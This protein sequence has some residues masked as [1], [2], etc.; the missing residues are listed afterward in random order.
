MMDQSSHTN[1]AGMEHVV[2][3]VITEESKEFAV[4]VTRLD[5]IIINYNQAS[6]TI[7]RRG[8]SK[9]NIYQGSLKHFTEMRW[10]EFGENSN[11]RIGVNSPRIIR[12]II[13]QVTI[14]E[15]FDM[16]ELIRGA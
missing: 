12:S 4:G 3:L 6:A 8:H 15:S 9:Q 14:Q 2:L 16:F 1:C 11:D 10:F 7:D 13:P 5:K